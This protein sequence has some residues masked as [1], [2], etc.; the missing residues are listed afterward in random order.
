MRDW[1]FVIAT[2]RGPMLLSDA[3][4]KMGRPT[5]GLLRQQVHKQEHRHTNAQQHGDN[6]TNTQAER[7]TETYRQPERQ[8][9]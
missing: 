1:W 3:G 8:T 7:L 9:D 5:C 4:N 6:E 2:G